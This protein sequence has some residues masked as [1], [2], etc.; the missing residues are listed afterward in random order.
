MKWTQK[1]LEALYQKANKTGKEDLAF[2][3]AFLK[4]PK[5]TL[6]KLAGRELPKDFTLEAIES[7]PRYQGAYFVPSF[8]GDE[9]DMNSLT[10]VVGGDM[11]E[12]ALA[13]QEESVSDGSVGFSIA[14]IVSVCGVEIP[15][16]ICAA[17]SPCQE[18]G[19]VPP[20]CN[21]LYCGLDMCGAFGPCVQDVC[22]GDLS[23]PEDTCGAATGPGG[24]SVCPFDYC[25]ANVCAAYA[26]I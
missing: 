17:D 13:A 10:A 1:E 8:L 22:A 9:V 5:G 15:N 14:L 25:A 26:G 18:A 12:Q 23:C 6:E 7:D 19:P 21:P 24:L 3:E 11:E 2:R 20:V 4:D 16:P